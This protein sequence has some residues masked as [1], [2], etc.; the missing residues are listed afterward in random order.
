MHMRKY[1]NT[2]IWVRLQTHACA[3]TG[4]RTARG[5]DVCKHLHMRMCVDACLWDVFKHMHA[6]TQVLAQLAGVMGKHMY[7]MQKQQEVNFAGLGHPALHL[8]FHRRHR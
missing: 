6:H 8:F 7:E 1:V 4:P 3:H 5:S 2:C